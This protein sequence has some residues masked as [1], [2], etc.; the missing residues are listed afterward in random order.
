MAIPEE[1][2]TEKKGRLVREASWKNAEDQTNWP[3]LRSPLMNLDRARRS[4]EDK[5][6]VL[7]CV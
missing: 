2:G 3:S 4:E 6:R 1:E 7:G 5:E